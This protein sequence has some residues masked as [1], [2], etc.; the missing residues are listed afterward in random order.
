[1]SLEERIETEFKA[2]LKAQEKIKLSTIRML[3]AEINNF[4]LDRN[5]K[6]LKDDEIVKIIQ[7]QVKQHKDS[8]EQ[9]KKGNRHDLV[10]KE[11][12]ELD[13]LLGY[14]PEQ[15]SEEELKKI[16]TETIKE[17]EATSKKDMGKV[18]KAVME[19]VKG[20][21]EGKAVSQIVSGILK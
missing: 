7:H 21:A 3:K 16:I 8:I 13:I 5:K 2:A 10:E 9:F 14:M 4:K 12:K 19:K 11:T 6:T 17:L 18:I 20:K 15:M 1:M